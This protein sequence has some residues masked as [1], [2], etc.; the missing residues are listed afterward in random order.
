MKDGFD[1]EVGASDE[2]RVVV[3]F[4]WRDGDFFAVRV[5]GPT[6]VAGDGASSVFV[7]FLVSF[8]VFG[9]SGVVE[10]R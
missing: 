5:V 2:G 7:V 9:F 3:G 10:R 4:E 1:Y 8:F 6:V